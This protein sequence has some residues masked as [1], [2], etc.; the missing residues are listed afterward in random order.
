MGTNTLAAKA[1]GNSVAATDPNQFRTAFIG[2]LIP[3]TSDGSASNDSGALGSTTYMWSDLFLASGGVINFN[4]GN[5]TITHSADSLVCTAITTF[6]NTTDTSDGTTNGALKTSGGMYIAKDVYID[7][8]E[9]KLNSTSEATLS[10]ASDTDNNGTTD[11]TL[12]FYI[13]GPGTT[14]TKV[15]HI[16]YDE[17]D[18]QFSLGYGDNDHLSF[19]STGEAIFSGDITQSTSAKQVSNRNA[20]VV[21]TGTISIDLTYSPGP[22]FN[23]LLYVSVKVGAAQWQL[24]ILHIS[25]RAGGNFQQTV[26]ATDVVG[27]GANYTITNPSTNIIT[28]TNNE[29]SSVSVTLTWIGNCQS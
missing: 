12:A 26:I 7:G 15:G 19:N 28:L 1:T 11:V 18:N 21:A 14:G 20:E 16:R 25:G 4:N 13:N 23:G 9:L 10:I 2:D 22:L 17:S 27:A 5:V 29:A 24:D 6:S 3:R 8:G